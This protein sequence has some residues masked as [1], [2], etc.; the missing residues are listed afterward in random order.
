MSGGGGVSEKLQGHP[1]CGQELASFK[2]NRLA[3][4]I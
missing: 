1:G 4:R 2:G 3:I